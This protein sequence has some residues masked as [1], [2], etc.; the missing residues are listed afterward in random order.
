M[1]NSLL[2]RGLL[3]DSY[4][5]G[6]KPQLETWLTAAAEQLDAWVQ[7]PVRVQAVTVSECQS[8]LRN[9]RYCI[10]WSN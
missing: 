8:T 10:F 7:V 9:G 1:S 3:P 4:F 6:I 2:I 5:L